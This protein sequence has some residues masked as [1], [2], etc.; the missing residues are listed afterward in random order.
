MTAALRITVDGLVEDTTAD[1]DAIK[2]GVGGGWIQAIALP[3]GNYMYMDEE[4]KLKNFAYNFFATVLA[5]QVLFDEDYIAGDAV[6][7]GPGDSDGN[8]MDI[9]QPADIRARV[10]DMKARLG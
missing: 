8:H 5:R 7:C 2:A 1:Y 10:E 3:D 6:I 9:V 4:G